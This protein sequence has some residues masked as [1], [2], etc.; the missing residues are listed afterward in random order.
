MFRYS[1]ELKPPPLGCDGGCSSVV[2]CTLMV[3]G[4]VATPFDA[5]HVAA[6]VIPETTT[7]VDVLGRMS[8]MPDGAGKVVRSMTRKRSRVTAPPL[9]LVKRRRRSSVPKVELFAGSLVKSR[10]RF[11]G[12][13]DDTLASS[14]VV[15]KSR[16]RRIGDARFSGPG[17]PRRW[18][19]PAEVPLVSTKMKSAA[20][21]SVSFGVEIEHTPMTVI[22]PPLPQVSR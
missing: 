10:T 5:R 19:A 15:A 17:A 13:A 3:H 20:L 9:L 12:L 21:L 22:E 1:V 14:S 18:P 16:L 6:S 8:A 7:S 2:P 11:G 4:V